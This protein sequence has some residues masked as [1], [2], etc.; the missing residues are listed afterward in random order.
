M[1]K[2][3]SL[4]FALLLFVQVFAQSNVY[5]PTWKSLDVCLFLHGLQMLNLASLSIGGF[6]LFRCGHLKELMK[7]GINTGLIIKHY[8]EMVSLQ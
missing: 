1:K 5:Y 2:L 4:V 3:F 8:L 7:N 6:I